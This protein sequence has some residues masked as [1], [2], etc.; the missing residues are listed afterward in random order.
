MSTHR[1]ISNT[2]FTFCLVFPGDIIVADTENNRVVVFFPDGR[3]KSQIGEKGS[4]PHQLNH[5]MCVALTPASQDQHVAVTDSVNA[6]VKVF[7]QDG[8]FVAQYSDCAMFDFPY[9]IAISHDQHIVV[10]DLCNSS[11][12]NW[13]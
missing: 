5:P 12:S 9:G 11:I 1:D 4:R 7:R 8:S 13:M 10:S 3:P 2:C 6:C